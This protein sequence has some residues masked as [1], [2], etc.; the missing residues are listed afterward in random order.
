MKDTRKDPIFK[1]IKE[2]IIDDILGKVYEP[3]DMIPS[4][5][6]YARKY[7]VSRLTVR[8]A[9]DELVDKGILL[10]EKGK[11]TFVQE[12]A[13]KT[14]SYRRMSGFSS[15]VASS[16]VKVASKVILIEEVV[17]DKRAALHLKIAEN[18][19]V[20]HI[21]RLRY[22]NEICVSYQK[23]FLARERVEGIDFAA[24]DLDHNSLYNVLR[25][26]AGLVPSYVDE[27]FRAVRA[28]EKIAGYFGG[29]EGDPVLY[30]T[31]TTYDAANT[32][33]EFCQNY[34][35]TDV[36]GVWVKSVSI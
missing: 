16:K 18:A 22:I 6:E 10:T 20:V 21:E 32:P 34:E 11:G 15:N 8:R 12:L 27:Y 36:N 33:I 31:R 30:V 2:D 5:E 28:S 14:Y 9:I 7:G 4:Q 3:G 13:V 17:A 35:T 29:E 1:Q 26:R 24:E 19:P 23:S 25:A